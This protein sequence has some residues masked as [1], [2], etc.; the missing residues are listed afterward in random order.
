MAVAL[1]GAAT[2]DNSCSSAA[3]AASVV[4]FAASIA[5]RDDSSAPT[6]AVLEMAA[7]TGLASAAGAAAAPTSGSIVTAVSPN[8]AASS[9]RLYLSAAVLELLPFD[10]FAGTA[11][12]CTSCRF[13]V[14][15]AD[16]AA[17]ASTIN[18]VPGSA[19]VLPAMVASSTV[20]T[21]HARAMALSAVPTAVSLAV[22][23][24]ADRMW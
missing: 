13:W 11:T 4:F 22:G 6:H 20:D 1:R 5:V 9:S 12:V 23:I 15:A 3:M 19:A 10:M 14:S 7:S 2:A 18:P 24:P 21:V 16:L 8:S 17:T